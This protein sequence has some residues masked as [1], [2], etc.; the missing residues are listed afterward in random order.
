MKNSNAAI[1]LLSPEESKEKLSP[2]ALDLFDHIAEILADEY[3]KYV[4]EQKEQEH[5]GS[6]LR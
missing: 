3:V 5:E 6:D 2:A 4:N 1:D